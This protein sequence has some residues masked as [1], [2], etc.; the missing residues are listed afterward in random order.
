MSHFNISR[1]LH[2]SRLGLLFA[3]SLLISLMAGCAALGSSAPPPLSFYALDNAHIT[4]NAA[5][6]PAPLALT[7]PAT[8][9]TLAVNPI[10]AASG[11][12][13]Q[14][15]IYTREAHQLEHFAHSQWIDTP[16]RMLA[17]L[18]VSALENSGTFRAVILSPSS[19]SSDLRLHSEIVRLQQEFDSSPSRVRFTLRAYII[20][21]KS[22]RIVAVREFDA[23][24]ATT[25]DEPP[26]GVIATNRAVHSVLEQLASFCSA[27]SRHWP[28]PGSQR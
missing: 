20:E 14:H 12:N 22:R 26:A 18:I 28:A 15:M 2:T 19:A 3:G 16:A 23:S 21:N 10:H 7:A 8:A 1:L 4:E 24:V 5:S 25:S 13:S 6:R 11:F 17:P 9:L 27:A